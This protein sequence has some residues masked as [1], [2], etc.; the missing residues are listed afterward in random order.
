MRARKFPKLLLRIL[1]VG[2]MSRTRLR[3]S[4]IVR[5]YD[6]CKAILESAKNSHK[7]ERLPELFSEVEKLPE[8]DRQWFKRRFNLIQ[9]DGRFDYA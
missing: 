6:G 1:E 8:I 9:V 5:D 3:Q 4:I 2:D 7:P